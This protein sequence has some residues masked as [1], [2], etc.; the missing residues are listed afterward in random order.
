[1]NRLSELERHNRQ[2]RWQAERERIMGER[3]KAKR[4]AE[5]LGR[6][7]VLG[8]EPEF[9][10]PAYFEPANPEGARLVE[11]VELSGADMHKLFGVYAQHPTGFV[12][13]FDVPETKIVYEPRQLSAEEHFKRMDA[14]SALERLKTRLTD[15]VK[16]ANEDG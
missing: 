9:L 3:A 13:Y 5:E 6:P 2:Q 12:E 8:P 10:A 15:F 14:D 11:E 1:M 7:I 4:E 16:R